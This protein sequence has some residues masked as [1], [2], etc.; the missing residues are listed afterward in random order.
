MLAAKPEILEFECLKIIVMFLPG[1]KTRSVL[2]D[3]TLVS[4]SGKVTLFR[5]SFNGK[6]TQR[7]ISTSKKRW[8]N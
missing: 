3:V 5:V 2:D 7:A 4:N 6:A 8:K 1:W